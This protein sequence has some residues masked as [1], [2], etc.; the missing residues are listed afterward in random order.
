MEGCGASKAVGQSMGQV[1]PTYSPQIFPLPSSSISS[2]DKGLLWGGGASPT[3]GPTPG[4]VPHNLW[5]NT[6]CPTDTGVSSGGERMGRFWGAVGWRVMGLLGG[7]WSHG[8]MGWDVGHSWQWQW[9]GME[10]HGVIGRD[11]ESWSYGVGCG[12]MGVWVWGYE[13]MVQCKFVWG[14]EVL[15]GVMGQHIGQET[16]MKLW[17]GMS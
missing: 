17:S 8:A 15:C 3:C 4:S 1:F 16:A 14:H 7:I 5:D 10:S 9:G 13:V 2:K 12:V 6:Q 11:M